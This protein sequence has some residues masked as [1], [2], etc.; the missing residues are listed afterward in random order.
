LVRSVLSMR[1]G[2]NAAHS[3]IDPSR[4]NFAWA[5]AGHVAP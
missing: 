4:G 5:S 3:A 1:L 2:E